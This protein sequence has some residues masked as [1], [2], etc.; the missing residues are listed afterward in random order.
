MAAQC[1]F[2]GHYCSKDYVLR[3]YIVFCLFSNSYNSLCHFS[4][5]VKFQINPSHFSFV[6]ECFLLYNR[7][8]CLQFFFVQNQQGFD[9]TINP[10]DV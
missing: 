7:C 5:F 4:N 2:I 3:L 9:I 6:S 8:T 10:L 1:D